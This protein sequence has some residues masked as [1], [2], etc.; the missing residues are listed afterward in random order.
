MADNTKIEWADA[1]WNPIRG[2][3]RVS[4]G[5][6]HCYAEIVAALDA[7][8]GGAYEGLIARGGQWNGNITV[9]EDVIE[10][11]LRWTRPRKI[12]VNSMSD[13]FHENLPFEIVDRLFAVMAICAAADIGHQFQVLTKRSGRMCAYLKSP[14]TQGRI[15]AEIDAM[16]PDLP[17][18]LS[19]AA[20]GPIA[21]PLANVWIGVSVEDQDCADVRVPDLLAAPAAVRWLSME[22]LLGPVDLTRYPG[23]ESLHWV[24]VGGESGAKA[25]PMQAEWPAALRDQ[26]ASLGIP[27]LF[28]QWGE[29]APAADKS[30]GMLLIGKAK[31]G[32]LLEGSQHDGYP[33]HAQG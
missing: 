8:P 30:Y 18:P 32:R 21:W 1:T 10:Q 27:Y 20:A 29:W 14:G 23:I 2:C 28:K 5:C 22:P 11:P 3:S 7:A 17:K 24:V 13:L 25:R 9:V 33:I 19:A 15:R 4:E 31:A 26:C 6:R 12:F 16:L